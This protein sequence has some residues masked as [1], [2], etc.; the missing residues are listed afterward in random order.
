V[1]ERSLYSMR[2]LILSQCRLQRSEDGCDIGG[3]YNHGTCKTFVNLL[4]AWKIVVERERVIKFG[5]DNRG[6][7]G[8]GCFRIKERTDTAEFLECIEQS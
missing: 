3:A 4:E 2:S 5:V 8:I 7:K 1:S 6:S